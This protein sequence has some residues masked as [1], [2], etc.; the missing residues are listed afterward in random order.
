VSAR[1]RRLLYA[2][3]FLRAA[4]TGLLGVVLGLHLATRGFD[5]AAT[6]R[7]VASGLAGAAAAVL[8]ATLAGDRV[9]RRRV[10]IALTLCA[11]GGGLLV[12]RASEPPV[13]L[14]AAFAGMLNGVGR[15]RGAQLVLEQAA[16]P[17]TTNA[18]G[19]TQAFA[20]YNLL[21]D[22]GLALGAL[23]AGWTPVA[24]LGAYVG[25]V[26]ASGLPY[27]GLSPAVDAAGTGGDTRLSPEGRRTIGRIAA[28]FFVDSVAGG[29]IPGALLSLFFSER[30]GVGAGTL[31]LLFCGARAA[32]AASHLLAARLARRIGLVRTM[33]FTHVPSSL[34][35]VTVPLAPTFA[36]AAALFLLREGLVEMD[37]PTRQ[38]WVMALVRPAERT[39]AAGVTNLVRLV[40]WGLGSLLAGAAMADVGWSAPLFVAA[41]MKLA[42]DVALYRA[43]RSVRPPEEAA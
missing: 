21:Q 42:Y 9:G 35:L 5:V 34:L 11:V 25:L 22:A 17:A 20:W 29:F 3:G 10:L 4:A 19:R 41:A 12:S 26:A 30:F 39:V 6:G 16:L 14:V 24:S 8:I 27:L 31:G 18:A 15:D 13:V 43:F 28:L 37:V 33:V 23:A 36:I 38:S 40:G 7:V 2:A 1:D 32:N